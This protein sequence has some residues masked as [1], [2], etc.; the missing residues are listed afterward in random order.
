MQ[1][2]S[3]EYLLQ[4]L[5]HDVRRQGFRIALGTRKVEEARSDPIL[6]HR[7]NLL[8]HTLAFFF[9]QTNKNPT[10]NNCTAAF[11]LQHNSNSSKHRGGRDPPVRTRYDGHRANFCWAA[12]RRYH[13]HHRSRLGSVS[14]FQMQRYGW[15]LHP[16]L[17]WHTEAALMEANRH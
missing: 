17:W 6:P 12:D 8:C 15:V 1:A 16:N 7:T 4:A 3:Q 11:S 5:S 14:I 10:C 9:K 13:T 2:Q